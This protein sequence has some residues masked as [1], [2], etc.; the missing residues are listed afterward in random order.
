MNKIPVIINN[1]DLLT[2]PR[3]MV[4]KIKTYDNVGD[5]IILDNGS[6]YK[7]LLDWYDTNPCT[8]IRGE[9][10]G[11]TG[12]WS[13][14]LVNSLNSEYY[15][16]TDGDMG[17]DN[18]PSNTLSYLQEKIDNF[19]MGKV[20]LGLEWR[21]IPENSKLYN[22]IQSYEKPRWDKSRII[23][24]LYLDIPIDTTFALYTHQHYFIGGA[25]TT[26]PYVAEHFPWYFTQKELDNNYEFTY[27]IKNASNSSCY[28]TYFGL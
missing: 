16:V 23:D 7:P 2:W 19:N 17:L 4:E 6:T 9:N 10:L 15:V 1:R 28:K 21:K 13:S 24:D 25:S 5:I 3:K 8:I 26:Y 12:P 11:H 22:H 14:G 20:G 27:Y 18:T